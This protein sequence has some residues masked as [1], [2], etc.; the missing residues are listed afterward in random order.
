[1]DQ[2][3]AAAQYRASHHSTQIGGRWWATP[4]HAGLDVTTR[5]PPGA[6]SASLWLTKD[7]MGGESADLVPCT[8]DPDAHALEIDGPDAWASPVAT[9]PLGVT[10]SRAPTW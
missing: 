9:H 6:G 8:V 1:M 7:Q 10:S 3:R 2:E 5:A 4:A